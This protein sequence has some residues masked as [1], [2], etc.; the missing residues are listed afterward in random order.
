MAYFTHTSELSEGGY[1]EALIP[2]SPVSIAVL[3]HLDEANTG[4]ELSLFSYWRFIQ[5][6]HFKADV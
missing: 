6:R 1:T 2:D 5:S 3:K 4:Q